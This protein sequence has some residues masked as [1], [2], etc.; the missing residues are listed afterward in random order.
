MDKYSKIFVSVSIFL[1]FSIILS[2]F[3]ILNGYREKNREISFKRDFHGLS[4]KTHSFKIISVE[5][6]PENF[7]DK[8]IVRILNDGREPFNIS[9]LSIFLNGDEYELEPI[10]NKIYLDSGSIAA[11]RISKV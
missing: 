5:F 3:L 7:N 6:N 2:S 8:P 4:N 1:L 9:E 11:M 10:S